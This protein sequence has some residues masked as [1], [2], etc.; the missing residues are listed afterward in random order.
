MKSGFISI[1]GRP[2][3]GKST[4][5]NSIIGKKI[6]I[7]SNK[8]QTTRNL[9]QGIYN[10]TDSQLVFM[11]TPGIH[12]PNHKLGDMLNKQAYY[13]IY[14]V[15]VII[16][17]VPCTEKIGSGDL[18]ILDKLKEVNKPVILVIN[19]VDLIKKEELLKLIDDYQKL[20]NFSEIVPLS[21]LKND[22]VK[23]LINVLKK[24]VNDS[25]K[26]YDEDT[27]TNKPISFLISE[28]VREKVMQL[29]SEEVPHSITCVTENMKKK[30]DKYEIAVSIIVD[31]DNLKSII[32]GKN[33]DMIKKIGT[34]A[35][36]DIET[37]LES[38]VYLELYVKTV[39]KWRD[40]DKYLKEFG[41]NE[42]DE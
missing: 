42:I 25:Y 22:N 33:G 24:Y 41:F 14:D 21:A 12:K 18:F 15:D 36:I 29:T 7:T 35:R 8:P 34:K 17:I 2:N 38:K 19:K 10:D 31:R 1:V 11:D 39:K 6:A 5:L 32:I 28:L 13:S 40:T 26:Y 27:I 4:L 3:V 23:S 20:Y 30:K 9:I 16:F 37:L